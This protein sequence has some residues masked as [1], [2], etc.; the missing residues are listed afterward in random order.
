M[1]AVQLQ[2]QRRWFAGSSVVPG[3]KSLFGFWFDVPSLLYMCSK[4]RKIVA[5]TNVVYLLV[6]TLCL[7]GDRGCRS[8]LHFVSGACLSLGQDSVDASAERVVQL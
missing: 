4:P 5:S 8:L 2:H 1:P 6:V 7:V 3:A